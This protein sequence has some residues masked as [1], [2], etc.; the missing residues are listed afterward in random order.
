MKKTILIFALSRTPWIGGVY[1][2]KNI[3]HMILTNPTIMAKYQL[4]IL[5]NK[6]NQAVFSELE[7]EATIISCDDNTRGIGAILQGVK[8]CIKYRIKYIFP[9]M[10][11]SFLSLF[12]I[13]P[14]SWIA[15]FQHNHYPEFFDREE[16]EDRNKNFSMIANANNPLVLSSYNALSD[17]EKYY[18]KQRHNVHVVHFTSFISDELRKMESVNQDEIMQKFGINNEKYIVVCNQFWKHKN[19]TVV[20]KAIKLLAEQH[21]EMKLQFVFTGELT[22][23]RNPKY[24]KELRAMLE[25]PN[26]RD[27]VNILGFIDRTSQLCVIK[28]AIFVLQ[29]SL[30]E[31]W[32]TVVEDSKIIGKRILLSDIPVHREQMNDACTLFNPEDP[33]ELSDWI[34]EIMSKTVEQCGPIDQT[35]EYGV[36]LENVF[37]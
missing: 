15:D 2:R 11:Y 12:G 29:P 18:V 10:P 27:R 14:V 21:P 32:G 1:Y 28:H 37:K 6:K 8:C 33:Q 3:A 25:E 34:F 24:Y 36:A 22:D 35:L 5:T 7:P 30:F 23:R 31:G 13:T 9:I 4:V 17:F 20:F 19:H 16:I 26:V